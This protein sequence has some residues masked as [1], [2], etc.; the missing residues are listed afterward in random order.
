MNNNNALIT[1]VKSIIKIMIQMRGMEQEEILP[2]KPRHCSLT[3]FSTHIRSSSQ[4][5]CTF[6]NHQSTYLPL[7]LPFLPVIGC[8]TAV[9]TFNH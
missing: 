2:L 9:H 7:P 4:S 6:Y 8:P 3:D 1:A 5:Q